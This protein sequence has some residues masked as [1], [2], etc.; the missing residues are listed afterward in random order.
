MTILMTGATGQVGRR[1]IDLLVAAGEPVRA[2]TR[3]PG[4]AGLPAAVDVRAGDL[5]RPDS[6][7]AAFDGA[8]QLYLLGDGDT[9]GLLEQACR[10]GVRHVVTLSTIQ[11]PGSAIGDHHRRTERLVEDSGLRWTHLRPGMFA[12][13]LGFWADQI[14]AGGVVREPC[15]GAQLEPVHPQDIAERAAA[16]LLGD[17]PANRVDEFIGPQSFTK[18]ELLAVVGSA[19]GRDLRFEEISEQ[20]Y[21][22][23]SRLPEF[24]VDGQLHHWRLYTRP[25]GH[26]GIAAPSTARTVH[27]WVQE[28]LDRFR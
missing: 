27:T 10:A 7:S 9:A 19:L 28:N 25:G 3:R 2:I 21:R 4:E 14:R 12:G 13:N 17:S 15:A 16:A 5:T 1:V 24:I 18:P 20:D 6:V 26:S 8:D 22:E 23:R 11:A